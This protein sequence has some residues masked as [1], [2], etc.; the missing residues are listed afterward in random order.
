MFLEQ[1][2][3]QTVDLKKPLMVLDLC[4]APG[5]K[6]TLLAS[7]LSED[8]LLISNEVIRSRASILTENILKWGYPNAV[9]TQND[10]SHFAKL[11]GLF[12]LI[13]VDA[14]C[15]GE[16]LFRK[17]SDAFAE[18]SPENVELCSLRQRRILKDV[19]PAL[20]EGGTLIYSTCTYNEHEDEETMKWLAEMNTVEFARIPIQSDWGIV[21]STYGNIVGYRFYPHKVKGEGF[22]ISALKKSTAQAPIRLHTKNNFDRVPKK[23]T[24]EISKWIN[25][26]ENF[27]FA[28]IR[29]IIYAIPHYHYEIIEV[30]NDKLNL[31]HAGI[32]LATSKHG[33]LVPEHGAALSTSLDLENFTLIEL[34]L[35][36]ALKYLRKDPLEL[37]AAQK[38][39]AIVMYQ[40]NP[41]G[42]INLLGNRINNLYPS[43][44]RIRMQLPN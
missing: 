5:G 25:E 30:L 11:E 26:P 6:S 17:D 27:K 15:S 32:P 20:K 9:V 3:K 37:T 28:T 8:S 31:L 19:W 40:Q 21:E 44:W 23:E 35:E 22:F 38:G 33:K 13:V 2:L 24:E 1:V 42:W 41:I 39:F 7:L 34:S 36:Q 12:D 4:A 16:G 43:N 14:P 10:P 18:W 29:N